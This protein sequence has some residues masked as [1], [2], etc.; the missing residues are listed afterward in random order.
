MKRILSLLLVL[1]MSISIFAVVR[2]VFGEPVLDQSGNDP[3]LSIF[4]DARSSGLSTSDMKMP[5]ED[6]FLWEKEGASG[7]LM[8]SPAVLNNIIYVP[9][10]TD[11]RAGKA[12][13]IAMDISSG[14]PEELW[15]SEFDGLLRGTP[16]ID[17]EK[18]MIY[19]SATTGIAQNKSDSTTNIYCFSIE[20][21]SEVW[22]ATVAGASFNSICL[23]N[24]KIFLAAFWMGPASNK[25]QTMNFDYADSEGVF[26]CLDAESGEQLWEAPLEGGCVQ[27]SSAAAMDGV[28]YVTNGNFWLDSKTSNLLPAF[29]SSPLYAF[30]EE[31]GT[32]L[33]QYTP[34]E[35]SG[36]AG[37]PSCEDGKVYAVM[38]YGD[39]STAVTVAVV[40]LNAESGTEEWKYEYAGIANNANPIITPESICYISNDTNLY[41]INKETGKKQWSKKVCDAPSYFNVEFAAVASQGYVF[42]EGSNYDSSGRGTGFR[43]QAFD[44]GAKGK[45][46]WKQDAEADGNQGVSVYSRN[47]FFC[48]VNNI[49]HFQTQSPELAVSPDKIDLGKVERASKKDI[50]LSIKNKGIPGLEGTIETADTWIKLSAAAFTDDTKEVIVTIDT[51]GLDIKEY[52]GKIQFTSNGG[53]KAI[54]VTLKVIDTTAPII[55]WDYSD[56][57]KVGEDYYT[58]EKQY[59]LKGSTEPTAK[60]Q[61]QGKEAEIDAE[62]KFIVT[63]DLV[64]GKNEIAVETADDVPNT[65]KTSFILFLDTKAP[66]ITLT[67]ENYTLVK[68]PSVYIMGQ[69]D[70]KDAVVTI[71]DEIVPLTPAGSFAKMVVVNKGENTFTIKAKDKIGNETA[72]ELI[73]VYPEK[74]LIVLVVGKKEAEVNGDIV[75]MDVAPMILKGSTMVPLRSLGDF[76]GAKVDYEPKE[77]KITFTLFGKVIELIIGR[78]TAKVNGEPVQLSVPPTIISGRTLVPLRFVSENLGAKVDYEAKS[79]TITISYPD[80][81][82]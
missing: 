63:V 47:V 70:D 61:I 25:F 77:Q 78:K 42:T 49:Y 53:N 58:K 56:L 26:Y 13:I 55:T 48:G 30:D 16:A 64:E 82:K 27:T 2:P 54:N 6:G 43:M 23:D 41:A 52:T 37:T 66:L 12:S 17:Q 4:H 74:K 19:I 50:K 40:C 39:F 35:N 69:V 60:V 79:R 24:N 1:F 5:L 21:G 51:T 65:S 32:L 3:W 38:C 31:S 9:Y 81:E 28:V 80:P 46:V 7:F 36:F 34:G 68:E 67:T 45:S 18:G 75:K 62:G 72:K 11:V 10:Q 59:K 20:D 44:L 8:G 22:T 73:I 29:R 57:I 33:W 76:L 15:R 71:N 14:E